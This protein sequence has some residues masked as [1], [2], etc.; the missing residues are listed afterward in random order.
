MMSATSA[1]V[2]SIASGSMPAGTKLPGR[3]HGGIRTRL[4]LAFGAVAATTVIASATA[5]L[6]FARVGA[7][8]DGIATRSIPAVVATL[9]LSTDT[10]ALV[11]TAPNLLAADT[12]EH[13]EAQR[14]AL[15]D[16]QRAVARQFAVVSG[17]ET[18]E[19]STA[20]LRKL[21]ADMT[22][23]LTA[24]DHAVAM[25]IDLSNQRLATAKAN[26]QIQAALV[27]TLKP[28]I[29]A[30]QSDIT[31]VSMT[32]GG[33]A[34]DATAILLKL[35]SRQVPLAEGLSD[36]NA[37]VSLLSSQLDRGDAAPDTDAV[38]ALSKEYAA[39]VALAA[40]KL[41][42]VETLQSTPGLR[43]GVERLFA[44]GI[45]ERGVFAVRHRELEAQQDGR[46]LLVETRAVAGDL[47]SEVTRQA[48]SVRQ[49]ATEATDRSNAAIHFGIVVM[50]AISAA[51]V[52]G[53]VL[54]VWLY[55]GR[56]LVARLVNLQGLMLR[57]ANGDLTA[58]VDNQST[59]EIGQMADT[60]RVFRANAQQ[61]RDLRADADKVQA[62]NRRRQAAM[63]RHTQDFGTSVAGVMANLAHSAQDMRST[64]GEMSSAA[65]R[66]RD[67]AVRTAEGAT[68]SATNLA[69]VAAASEQMSASINEISQQAARATQAAQSAVARAS[70]TDIK[71]TGMAAL[72]DKIGD[73]VRLI[74]DIASRTNLL[75]LNATIEAAR[76]GD[77]GKGFAVVAGEVKALAT[78][79]A[80]ATDEISAQVAAI[81]TGT[82]DAV[83]AV[84]DVGS[85]ITEVNEVATAI[86][87]AVEQQAAATRDIAASVQTVA[88]ATQDATR[89]MQDVSAIAEQTD[90]ASATVMT[91][92]DAVG[93]DAETLRSEVTQ[94]L[95]VMAH[96]DEDERRRYERI[97]GN[98][99]TAVLHVPGRPELPAVI[100]DLSRGGIALQCGWSADPGTE[101]QLGLP[102]AGGLVVAR[103]VRGAGEVLGLAFRQEEAM[104]RRVD[105][106]LAQIAAMAGKQ[107]A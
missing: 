105:V 49:A 73:V 7:L 103:I 12:Q 26:D 18:S 19:A 38:D 9:Q 93:R 17:F 87:A 20:A 16:M 2:G 67:S 32:L 58:T 72:A 65:Q 29:D 89:A 21:I 77:A 59:D 43:D 35:V 78:Q 11:A 83:S 102:G 69:A 3:R 66:T 90:S 47:A 25:R 15:Q 95:E 94:F 23:K 54:V 27:A 55:I 80:R 91:G 1:P 36:L 52:L 70:T 5:W 64:A 71:V 14:N 40:E 50:L 4:F 104:L 10:Q 46:K 45:G 42:V 48:D 57:L 74:T 37:Q 76:A 99:A 62:R 44:Q 75:A 56:S 86:A 107:A 30:A 96:A 6:L 22:D 68:V 98:G 63:D 39:T 41:D 100:L 51:A 24:L 79:T 60:L 85:A 81:R 31:M 88:A 28:V 82:G 106:T 61:A 84:R 101:V 92:A 53:A 8:L 97:A 13:R 33:E 34:S